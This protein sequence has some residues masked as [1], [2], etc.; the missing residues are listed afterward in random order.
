MIQL[1]QFVGKQSSMLANSG[2]IKTPQLVQRLVR[3]NQLNFPSMPCQLE[4]IDTQL[5]GKKLKQKDSLESTYD[6]KRW[7]RC[8]KKRTKPHSDPLLKDQ[9]DIRLK[10]EKCC[11]LH[12]SF[13]WHD[14]HRFPQQQ[15]SILQRP[16]SQCN[17]TLTQQW[18]GTL[19]RQQEER[20][21]CPI[22]CFPHGLATSE[23]IS[24]AIADISED[25]NL[26]ECESTVAWGT[27]FLR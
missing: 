23:V 15:I 24:A 7:W 14:N 5:L 4:D 9:W 21:C 25:V 12:V 13:V 20:T 26:H 27:C 22:Q 16:L 11:R 3:F 10:Y 1:H 19:M 18:A 8:W 2:V 6:G 17:K